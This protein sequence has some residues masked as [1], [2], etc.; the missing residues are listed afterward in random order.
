MDLLN[1]S[2]IKTIIQNNGLVT[3]AKRTTYLEGNVFECLL[4]YPEH[5]DD[6]YIVSNIK[7]DGKVAGIIERMF[8]NTTEYYPLDQFPE[9]IL[10]YVGDFG[11]ANWADKTK[12][13]KVLE[14]GLDYWNHLWD[15]KGKTVVPIE[16]HKYLEEQKINCL[17][18]E[19]FPKFNAADIELQ[20]I[21]TGLFYGEPCK[22]LVDILESTDEYV[23]PWDL[24]FTSFP[25]DQFEGKVRGLRYDIQDSWYNDLL[26]IQFPDKEVRPMKFLVWNRDLRIITLSE[27]TR[28]VARWGI[29]RDGRY[30]YDMNMNEVA[31]KGIHQAMQ[32]YLWSKDTGINYPKHVYDNHGQLTVDAYDYIPSGE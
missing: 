1:Q 22:G 7:L 18:H 11:G 24:K 13:T 12:I 31:I 17:N 32:Q 30:G 21:T 4:L 3:K 9:S 10:P 19:F 26:K 25:V 27:H 20:Y 8:E 28:K 23:Q 15:A 5:F 14:Q 29:T 6:L 16:M 2:Q